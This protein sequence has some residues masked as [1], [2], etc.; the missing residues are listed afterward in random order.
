LRTGSPWVPFGA[1]REKHHTAR[2]V[3]RLPYHLREALQMVA[4]DPKPLVWTADPKRVL[5]G[6]QMGE[7]NVRLSPPAFSSL[8]V[9][10]YQDT[11]NPPRARTSSPPTIVG[12]YGTSFWPNAKTEATQRRYVVRRG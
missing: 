4:G 9:V 3:I 11:D 2:L 5:A 10:E 6:C 12:A 1:M 8:S 7:A